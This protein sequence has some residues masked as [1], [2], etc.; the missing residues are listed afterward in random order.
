MAELVNSNISFTTTIANSTYEVPEWVELNNDNWRTRGTNNTTNDRT[1]AATL[2]ADILEHDE[3]PQFRT[4][5]A[6]DMEHPLRYQDFDFLINYESSRIKPRPY[7]TRFFISCSTL[8]HTLGASE[9]LVMKR[10]EDN[11]KKD[12]S[13]KLIKCINNDYYMLPSDYFDTFNHIRQ[14]VRIVGDRIG[15]FSIKYT[16]VIET[17]LT[18]QGRLIDKDKTPLNPK[19]LSNLFKRD[20]VLHVEVYKTTENKYIY[21]YEIR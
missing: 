12:F 3:N 15:A 11:V 4:I 5:T 19:Q 14:S 10:V 2:A 21:G 17:I 13:N 16:D 18:M 20:M 1:D 7:L 8:T 9:E 6:L